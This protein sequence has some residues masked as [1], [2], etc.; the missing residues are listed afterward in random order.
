MTGTAP[1]KLLRNLPPGLRGALGEI[2]EFERIG[3][4]NDEALRRLRAGK[5]GNCLVAARAQTAG[6]GRR[7]HRWV[8]PEG[9]GL[10]FSLVREM[11][12]PL[13]GILPLGPV[14]ALALRAGLGDCEVGGIGVK[15]PNDLLSGNR[16]LGGV[17]VETHGADCERH[18]VVGV[19]LNLR[20]PPELMESIDQP[21][22]DLASI[23]ADDPPESDVAAA[24]LKRLLEYI[25]RYIEGS[26][27]GFLP[28][29]SRFDRYHEQDVVVQSGAEKNIGRVVGLDEQ[30]ALLLRTATGIRRLVSGGIFP[31]RHGAGPKP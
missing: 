18:V 24:V 15:W 31:S 9:A 12:L 19:G 6:R 29:W 23:C 5:A 26:F 10:Y 22:V 28:E 8:S 21:A 11:P 20:F 7:G 2:L 4:T 13:E 27:A 25:D 3:S 30:G 16:K 1:T 17:L 14:V